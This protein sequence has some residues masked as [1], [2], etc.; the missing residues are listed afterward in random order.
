MDLVLLEQKHTC[1]GVLA[2]RTAAVGRSMEKK[3]IS[4]KIWVQGKI[5]VYLY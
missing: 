2:H 1:C 5:G 3:L 4:S